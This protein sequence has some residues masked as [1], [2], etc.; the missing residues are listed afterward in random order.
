DHVAVF[1]PADLERSE[2]PSWKELCESTSQPGPS[3]RVAQGRGEG[4]RPASEGGLFQ[5]EAELPRGRAWTVVRAWR[6]EHCVCDRVSHDARSGFQQLLV[7]DLDRP[8]G[9]REVHDEARAQQPYGAL[10]VRCAREA[11]EYEARI[12]LLDRIG[13]EGLGD[14]QSDDR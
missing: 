14:E 8:V 6:R 5:E 13:V 4:P 12:G 3:A 2:R 7:P 11:R 10:V 9:T 1:V